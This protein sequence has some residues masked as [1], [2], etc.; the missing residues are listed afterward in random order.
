MITR[1]FIFR[2]KEGF[3]IRPVSQFVKLVKQASSEVT[4]LFDDEQFDGKSPLSIMSACIEDGAAFTLRVHGDDEEAVMTSIENEM[5]N[6]ADR[7]F[8]P[9]PN[10]S[11]DS[12]HNNV[13]AV[14]EHDLEQSHE[15][16]HE[17]SLEQS[18]EQ[19]TGVA[20]SE[21]IAI[22]PAYIYSGLRPVAER[23]KVSDPQAELKR[24]S[25]AVTSLTTQLELLR[26]TSY[27]EGPDIADAHISL[28]SD[29]TFL[30]RI[31]RAALERECSAEFVVLEVLRDFEAEYAKMKNERIRQRLSDIKDICYGLHS[32]LTGV[33]RDVA[34]IPPGSIIV[35][36]DLLPSDTLRILPHK[37]AGF[38]LEGGSTNS[39]T[40]IV[41]KSVELPAIVGAAGILS[42]VS[43]GS[44]IAMDGTKGQYWIEP[45]YEVMDALKS[46][47]EAQAKE[48]ETLK[49]YINSAT[50]TADG[51]H[52]AI[53]ANIVSTDDMAPAIERGA[54]GVGLFRT[55]FIYMNRDTPPSEREQFVLYGRALA[56][57]RGMPVT[58][59]TLDMGGDKPITCLPSK[60]EDNPFLG[61]RGI[62]YSLDNEPVFREQIRALLRASAVGDLHIMLPMITLIEE[63]R[64]A[65]EIILEEH[66]ALHGQG[67]PI[68]TYKVGIMIETPA[69]ALLSRH[70][71]HMVD[72]FSIGS[73]DL[74]QYTMA[75]DRGNAEVASV[76]SPYS[77][78]VLSLIKMTADAAADA[79]IGVS[80]C[81][82]SAADP[83]LAPLYL[84]LGIR[85]LSVVPGRITA[86][87]RYI[88]TLDLSKWTQVCRQ[89]PDLKRARDVR[90]VLQRL[91]KTST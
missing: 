53:F 42:L 73:N 86:L 62:R 58:I 88:N 34:C 61:K 20:A 23:T 60:A 19:N 8:E 30:E 59:R 77:P 11:N 9:V 49:A 32:E 67:S 45:D 5:V 55:E 24:L 56:G 85:T 65:S 41:A 1:R 75:A 44:T 36:Q 46:K 82:E 51:V 22:G 16:S 7:Y 89:I 72:F 29:D 63:V 26:E 21:G 35:A 52:A 39:H 81:G 4:I 71:A 27:G 15:Q 37:V 33:R 54:E 76:G 50:R 91:Y 13:S 25:K 69:A 64:R 83:L 68:G 48:R 28:L 84:S 57:A 80:I 14:V 43:A 90:D 78:A 47:T 70:L 74:I 18:L 40:A 66:A 10:E 79:C 3:H 6:G 38:I 17:Q 2:G 31:S 87:R 12:G